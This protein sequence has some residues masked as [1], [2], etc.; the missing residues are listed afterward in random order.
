MASFLWTMTYRQSWVLI[1]HIA[2]TYLFIY[3]IL[4]RYYTYKKKWI[5][6][7][8]IFLLLLL[9]LFVLNYCVVYLIHL[10]N[11]NQDSKA[12]VP[13]LQID[14]LDRVKSVFF[15]IAFNLTTVVGIAVII[16]LMKRWLHKQ[17][18][19]ALIIEEKG[20]AELQLLKAQ[21]HPHFLFNSLNN[22]YAFALEGSSK[23]PEM[24]QKLVGLLKYM[25]QECKQPLVSV[26][27][28]LEM[29]SDYVSL[30]IIR[31]GDRLKIAME[32]PPAGHTQQ[33][34]PLLLIPFV[35]NSFKHGTSKMLARPYVQLDISIQQNILFFTLTNSKP[36]VSDEIVPNVN[37][38]LGLKNVKKRL[39][40]LYPNRHEL[41]I[42]EKPTTYTVWLK[43]VLSDKPRTESHKYI[44]K[45]IPVYERP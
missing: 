35:E 20:R 3:Y 36:I 38:G 21:V 10:H 15:Q 1:C 13:L 28:E 29:I 42:I 25:L 31:Y 45:E 30:E 9:A 27:T 8:G 12:G 16:K 17:K 34:A 24:I 18:E 40:L 37:R 14:T 23:A 26:A 32:F 2:F 22:I 44:T 43:I 6:T 11:S 19:T 33:I 39:S 41:R 7:T 5:T 4:P